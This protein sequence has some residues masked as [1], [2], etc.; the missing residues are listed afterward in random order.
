[1]YYFVYILFS[2]KLNRFYIG[3]TNDIIKRFD[4]HN[5]GFEKFTSKGLPWILLWN[6]KKS[7]R[8]EAIILETKL[9]NLNRKRLIELMKKYNDGISNHD[10][11]LFIEQLS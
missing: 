11:L 1:M 8:S 3:Q 10:E 2:R 7:T 4:R 5:K 6:T 9:K